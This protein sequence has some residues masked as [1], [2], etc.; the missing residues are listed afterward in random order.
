MSVSWK[1][2]F[3]IGIARE[4]CI[5]GNRWDSAI[6]GSPAYPAPL[7]YRWHRLSEE[8]HRG[9][10]NK[11]RGVSLWPAFCPDEK[12]VTVDG[13]A[14][15]SHQEFYLFPDENLLALVETAHEVNDVNREG[16]L[17]LLKCFSEE[18]DIGVR[19]PL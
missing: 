16:I 3:V 18:E 4:G 7:W 11:K 12:T 6:S 19:E 8:V 2:L 10:K 15:M 14:R 1:A 5:W 9:L 13:C 17:A